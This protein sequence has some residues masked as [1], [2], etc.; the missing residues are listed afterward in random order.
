[1]KKDIN[2]EQ[3]KQELET[4][5]KKIEHLS[6]KDLLIIVQAMDDEFDELFKKYEITIVLENRTKTFRELLEKST[7]GV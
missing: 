1:M 7:K 6:M 2:I 4:F 3:M 5:I